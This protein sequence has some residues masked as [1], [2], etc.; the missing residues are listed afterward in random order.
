MVVVEME[1]NNAQEKVVKM[2]RPKSK[3]P[4]VVDPN[5]MS[6]LVPGS[7]L[8]AV[9]VSARLLLQLLHVPLLWRF[10]SGAQTALLI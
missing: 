5:T 4:P 6:Q 2:K 7:V 8:Q 1:E 10:L 9:E 3:E